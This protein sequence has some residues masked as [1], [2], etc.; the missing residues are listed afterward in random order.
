LIKFLEI[1]TFELKKKSE[2]FAEQK[3]DFPVS[4]LTGQQIKYNFLGELIEVLT[5][6]YKILKN[7]LINMSN[8]SSNTPVFNEA[9]SPKF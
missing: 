9:F 4:F 6:S 8:S 5:Y 7:K 2:N 1:L 3:K